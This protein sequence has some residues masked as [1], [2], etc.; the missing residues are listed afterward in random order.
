[1]HLFYEK[2]RKTGELVIIQNYSISAEGGLAPGSMH[3]RPS[4]QPPIDT[5]GNYLAPCL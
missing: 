5:S 4:A 3:E 2:F 1:M